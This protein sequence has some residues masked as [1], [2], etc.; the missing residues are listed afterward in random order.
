MLCVAWDQ[1]ASRDKVKC[2]TGP[3]V[4]GPLEGGKRQASSI[5]QQALDSWEN[6][7]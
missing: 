1:E 2:A 3:F 7:G 4:R 6:I 5:K